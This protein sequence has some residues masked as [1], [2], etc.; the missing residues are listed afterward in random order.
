MGVL[1]LIL[2]LGCFVLLIFLIYCCLKSR[3]RR[4]A[5]KNT[6]ET[7][8][9]KNVW[10]HR[11]EKRPNTLNF[12]SMDTLM[13]KI[14]DNHT[15]YKE[16]MRDLREK[17]EN[18]LKSFKKK[19]ISLKCLKC[20][21]K[22]ASENQKIILLSC[23]HTFHSL[24]LSQSEGDK[25]Q[26]PHCA[27]QLKPFLHRSKSRVMT[28]G[29]TDSP[30]K[31]DKEFYSSNSSSVQEGFN[32]NMGHRRSKNGKKRNPADSEES[33]VDHLNEESGQNSSSYSKDSI[34][35]RHKLPPIHRQRNAASASSSSSE[36][37]DESD[38][39]DAS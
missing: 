4:N 36:E 19:D 39:N 3:K 26:C 5:S 35:S 2:T 28:K 37:L 33:S 8:Q 21:E 10:N 6:Q 17:N 34:P 15:Q 20:E 12:T 32:P 22:F 18:T 13:I 1:V 31:I 29:E 25:N 16:Y 23:G 7:E 11:G 14:F 38:S 9:D 24:C 27:N 30:K